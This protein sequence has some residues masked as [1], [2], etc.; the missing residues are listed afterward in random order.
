MSYLPCKNPSCKSHGKPHP[1]CKCYAGMADGGMV[2][3]Y[4]DSNRPHDRF[5][6]YFAEGGIVNPPD[7][8]PSS[9][10]SS[11][12][13][14]EGLHGLIKIG[15]DQDDIYKY[16]QAIKRGN[17]SLAARVN[18]LFGNEKYEK[19]DHTKSRKLIEEWI[20][21]GGIEAELQKEMHK[22]SS[23]EM[24]AGGGMAEKKEGM[25]HD[26]NIANS[27]PSQNVLLQAAKGRS[28]NYLA[29]LKPQKNQPK[30]AF[31]DEPDQK[32][33][34]KSYERAIKIAADPLRVLR[35]IKEGTIEPEHIHHFKS[36]YPEMNEVLQKK[37]TEKIIEAQMKGEKPSYKVRQG[38]S[39]FM[40]APMSGEMTPQNIMAAQATFQ[41]KQQQPPPQSKTSVLK[42]ADDTYMTGNQA[43][44]SREQKQT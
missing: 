39:V 20:D 43:R 21:S 31:D 4:C 40:G 25:A 38:L 15:S 41:G 23:P 42:S 6:K 5:C 30:L 26:R 35:K 22:Q 28:A 12:L 34:R 32:K 8:D 16:N 37:I 24:F 1:N 7:I 29:G 2:E 13:G 44:T 14:S 10:V 9:A 27:Y 3:G 33:Q 11:F 19:P 17:K 36:L 18:D